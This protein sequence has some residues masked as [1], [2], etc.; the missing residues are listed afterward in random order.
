MNTASVVRCLE[1]LLALANSI[2]LF[3]RRKNHEVHD[4]NGNE[5]PEKPDQ[6]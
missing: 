6:R 2:N 1:L 3:L 4:R 5:D